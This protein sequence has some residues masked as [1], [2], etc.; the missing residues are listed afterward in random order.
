ML[1]FSQKKQAD[2]QLVIDGTLNRR[3]NVRAKIEQDIAFL[4][5]RITAMLEQPKPNSMLIEHYQSMLTSRES[6]LRWLLDGC[7]DE[8]SYSQDQVSS[9]R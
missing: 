3:S 2:S 6:V 5:D 8:T 9:R 7:D 1:P 4:T